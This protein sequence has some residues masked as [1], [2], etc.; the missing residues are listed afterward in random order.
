MDV[1]VFNGENKKLYSEFGEMLFT[2]NGVS[3][4]IILTLSSKTTRLPIKNMLLKIDLKPALSE[5][6]LDD[7][8]LRDFSQNK[9]KQIKNSLDELL[10][11]SLIPFILDLSGIT[12]NKEINSVTKEER[13]RLI[14]LIKELTFEIDGTEDFD[15]AI[16]TSGGVNVKEITPKNMQSKIIPNLFFAGEVLDVD[17]LTGGFNL[18]IAFATGYILGKHIQEIKEKGDML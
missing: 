18:Q 3:G 4:P 14:H 9:N 5:K 16:I 12:Q 8:I 13:F 15:R 6:Q 2:E 17:A 7:R 1:S 11:K 10:P